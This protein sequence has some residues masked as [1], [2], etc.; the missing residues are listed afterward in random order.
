MD[1]AD[2]KKLKAF[3]SALKDS[4]FKALNL[5]QIP[6]FTTVDGQRMPVDK[7][8]CLALLRKLPQFQ[9]D[10]FK[11]DNAIIKYFTNPLNRKLILDRFSQAER[12]ELEKFLEVRPGIT[13]EITGQPVEQEAQPTGQETQPAV[14]GEPASTMTGRIPFPGIGGGTTA[15]ARSGRVV[16][17]RTITPTSTI[18]KKE[19]APPSKSELVVANKSG[20]VAEK[21]PSTI[22][23]ADK[24][25]RVVGEHPIPSPASQRFNWRGFKIPASFTNAAQNFGSFAQ[26]FIGTNLGRVGGGLGEMTKGLGR[27]IGSPMLNGAYNLLGKA[28]N[29]LINAGARL[30]NAVSGPKL[31]GIDPKGF[32]TGRKIAVV[33]ILLVAFFGFSLFSAISQPPTTTEANPQEGAISPVPT[34]IKTSCPVPGGSI[35]TPSYNANNANQQTG[36]CGGG[37]GYTC[38][39][40]TTGRRAKAIDVPTSGKAVIMPTVNAQEVTWRLIVGPYSVDNQEG[41]GVGYTFEATVGNDKWY[42]DMLHLNTG[43]TL[44]QTYPSGT[45]IGTTVASHVHMTM[46][47]NLATTPVA[48]TSTDCDPNWLPSDFMCK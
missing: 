16:E 3:F 24:S 35:S 19:G 25:G 21:P 26:R 30:S 28:G 5:N 41:G 48:G 18:V 12:V 38:N 11:D 31:G 39:C 40:G 8:Y 29:G 36:H 42:L 44:G 32:G 43:L 46:G 27:G 9:G 2:I 17:E 4:G 33:S 45:S 7:A 20:V 13:E 6:S 22:F 47:K 23:I 15:A 1:Y 34:D 10:Q 14:G 37:Y